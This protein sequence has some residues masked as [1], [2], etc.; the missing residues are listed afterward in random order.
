MFDITGDGYLEYVAK[1]C[2]AGLLGDKLL[3][4]EF[5]HNV[6]EVGHDEEEDHCHG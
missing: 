3:S 2:V 6:G 4:E 1:L 5:I